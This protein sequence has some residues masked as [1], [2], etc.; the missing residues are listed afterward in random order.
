METLFVPYA[1][2]P[3]DYCIK[4][5]GTNLYDIIITD[6]NGFTQLLRTTTLNGD[7]LYSSKITY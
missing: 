5:H 3:I 2:V 6:G 4:V 1:E 7:T